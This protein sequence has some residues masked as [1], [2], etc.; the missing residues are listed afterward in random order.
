MPN[1]GNIDKTYTNSEFWR[2]NNHHGWI[3]WMCGINEGTIRPDLE[4][5]QIYCEGCDDFIKNDPRSYD[6]QKYLQ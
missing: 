3:C 4:D 6:Y 2:T 5:I 1:T